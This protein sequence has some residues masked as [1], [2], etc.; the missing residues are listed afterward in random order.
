WDYDPA[1]RA[2]ALR[3]IAIIRSIQGDHRQA[4]AELEALLPHYHTIGKYHPTLYCDFLNSLAVELGETGRIVE[5][6]TICTRILSSP[7]APTHPHWF[8]T[9]DELAAKRTAA[10]PSII[11]VPAAPE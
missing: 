6:Q 5:A 1:T 3:E 8:E 10:T 7:F 4:V 2:E 11:A 9:R